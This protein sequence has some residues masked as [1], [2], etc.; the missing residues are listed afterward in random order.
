MG[1]NEVVAIITGAVGNLGTATARAF[2]VA[3]H[4]TV[5][6]DR[7]HDRLAAKFPDL[8]MS[9]YHMLAGG[10]DVAEA[11]VLDKLVAEILSRFGRIDVLVNTVGTWR[12]GKHVHEEDIETWDLLFSVNLRSTLL[13]CRAVVPRMIR[14]SRGKIINVASIS[15]LLGG[16]GSAAASASKSAVLRLTESLSAEL[17]PSNINV[18]CVLPDTIDTPQNR[19]AWPMAKFDKWVQPEAV[20]DLILFLASDAARGLHGVGIP[21]YGKG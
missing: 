9:P 2:H 6:V 11:T 10:V 4:R 15:A 13:C 20:A 12:G 18:N 19:A 16:A 17:K 21:V 14:Q 3:G 1:D 8:M 7:A 5:L